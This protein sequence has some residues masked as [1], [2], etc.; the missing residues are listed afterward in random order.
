MRAAGAVDELEVDV[1]RLPVPAEPDRHLGRAHLVEVQRRVALRARPRGSPAAPGSGGTYTSGST[2]VTVTSATSHTSAGSAPC[3]IRNT[4]EAN[5][6][7]SCT[8]STLVTT[9]AICMLAAAGQPALGHHHVVELRVLPRCQADR[10]LQ[11]RGGHGP[12]HQP[13]RFGHVG[14]PFVFGQSPG[15]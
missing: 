1:D 13:E 11:R 15:A 4:S 2:R 12:C 3:S 6:A 8:A 10:E 9:P 7:P 5:R 14:S